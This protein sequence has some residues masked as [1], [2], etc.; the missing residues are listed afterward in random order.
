MKKKN[1][2]G[3]ERPRAGR[4]SIEDKKIPITIYVRQSFIDGLGGSDALR[5]KILKSLGV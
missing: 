5:N 2:R 1:K 3:G 4:K